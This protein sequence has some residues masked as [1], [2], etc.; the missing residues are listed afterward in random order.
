MP[1]TA[2]DRVDGTIW[3]SNLKLALTD[4]RFTT[5]ELS[6]SKTYSYLQNSSQDNKCEALY[7]GPCIP[8]I[9]VYRTPHSLSSG[10]ELL[11]L[12]HVH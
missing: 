9:S 8:F 10:F 6:V 1:G 7:R 4:P 12:V 11:K 5:A 3:F 2:Y